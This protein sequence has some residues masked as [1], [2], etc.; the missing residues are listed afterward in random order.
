MAK[1]DTEEAAVDRMVGLRLAARRERLNIKQETLGDLLNTSQTT[2]S[3]FESGSR[4]IP[5]GL[6]FVIARRLDVT[7]EYFFE[8]LG[9]Y[10]AED[11]AEMQKVRKEQRAKV[12][13]LLSPNS[14]KTCDEFNTIRTMVESFSSVSG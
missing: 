12:A 4:T 9:K 5:A 8:G 2:I 1:T 14:Y 11:I 6:L 7:V 3:E 10:S 13:K